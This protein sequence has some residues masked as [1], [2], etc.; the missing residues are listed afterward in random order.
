ME[1]E[2]LVFVA[3]IM[4]ADVSEINFDTRYGEYEKW[5]SLMMLTL[6]MELEEKYAISIP[7]EKVGAIRT[8]RDL[9]AIICEGSNE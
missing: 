4:N 7:V 3:E 6:T 1:D 8:L 5:D 9:W 2:F